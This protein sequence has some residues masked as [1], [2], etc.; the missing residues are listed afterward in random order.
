[1]LPRKCSCLWYSW[2]ILIWDLIEDRC[3][4]ERYL[5]IG[6]ACQSIVNRGHFTWDCSVGL[7]RER[8]EVVAIAKVARSATFYEHPNTQTLCNRV[9]R[10]IDH[11]G[12]EVIG[13]ISRGSF[14]FRIVRCS[15]RVTR[16]WLRSLTFTYSCQLSL[17]CV[18]SLYE[19]W[20]GS[21]EDVT[22]LPM[23]KWAEHY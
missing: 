14:V 11:H 2:V 9:H 16:F 10:F 23:R 13:A 20:F 8:Q 19:Y 3:K 18:V 5:P 7:G 12:I 4:W 15:R 6:E 22:E 21:Q 1:M 17:S